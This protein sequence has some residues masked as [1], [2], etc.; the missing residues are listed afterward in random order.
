M[1]KAFIT[2]YIILSLFL[3]FVL[4]VPIDNMQLTKNNNRLRIL[5]TN[6]EV[7]IGTKLWYEVDYDKKFDAFGVITKGVLVNDRYMLTDK[8]ILGNLE[9]GKHVIVASFDIPKT[10]FVLGKTKFIIKIDYYIFSGLRILCDEVES[11]EFTIVK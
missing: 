5:N 6:K 11:E 8:P 4:F 3:F 9:S 2:L 10:D 1:T 7:K